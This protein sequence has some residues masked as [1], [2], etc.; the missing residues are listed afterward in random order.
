ME[1]RLAEFKLDL[2]ENKEKIEKL[3]KELEQARMEIK[4]L[5]QI[6]VEANAAKEKKKETV[7]GK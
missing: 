4:A 1:I 2:K 5:K 6:Q 3:S 7:E